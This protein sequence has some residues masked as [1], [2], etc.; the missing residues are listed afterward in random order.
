[1]TT[2]SLS[3]RFVSS[4]LLSAVAAAVNFGATLLVVRGFGTAVYNAYTVDLALLGLILLVLEAVPASFA[5]FKIQDDPGW[6][7]CLA[8]QA[9]AS[10]AL[11][12]ALTA[13]VAAGGTFRAFSVWM[14]AYA[15]LLGWRRYA[16]IRLQSSGRLAVFFGIDLG[17]AALRL[18]L[19]VGLILAGHA[20]ADAVWAAIA[21]AT[22][23]PLA[24]WAWRD[25]AEKGQWAG[26]ASSATW[27][28]LF[29][30]LGRQRPYYLGIVLKRLKDSLIP[31]AAEQVLRGPDALAAFF[32]AYRGVAFAVG[33]VRLLEALVNH[34]ASLAS[35]L[36]LA[37]RH[38]AAIGIGAQS[39]ALAASAAL[40]IGAG[41]ARVPWA[42]MALLSVSLWPLS[43]LVLERASAYSRYEAGRVNR[44]IVTYLAAAVLGTAL[45]RV[46]GGDALLLFCA[47]LVVAEFAGL[48]AI[49]R[50]WP[51][52]A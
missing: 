46:I 21:L 45:C 47:V 50:P 32:L 25:P 12:A 20:D 27:H 36:R 38:R 41:S 26:I 24:W 23:A 13:A 28:A 16:D 31:L 51:A 52:A 5:L 22:A 40:V 39:L 42:A 29:D 43:F 1:M 10:A 11:G 34:R 9:L 2:P 8:A 6:A 49:R 48:F 18:G 15:A 4:S 37:P 19:L 33:Q 3:R 14:V 17:A 7:R 30:D 44:S 35:A